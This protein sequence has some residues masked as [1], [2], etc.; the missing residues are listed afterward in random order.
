MRVVSHGTIVM[1]VSAPYRIQPALKPL[2]LSQVVRWR[3]LVT[4]IGMCR[5]RAATLRSHGY[6]LE[7]D[8]TRTMLP[9][10][11]GMVKRDL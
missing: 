4:G 9:L 8:S 11:G 1:A 6:L 10:R 7:F 3:F 2:S 5:V